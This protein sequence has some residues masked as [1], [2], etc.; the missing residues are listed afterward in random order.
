MSGILYVVGTPIGNL[1]DISE[2]ALDTLSTCDF[3]AAEDTRVTL[4]LLNRFEIK[5]TLI[6]YH[7]HNKTEAGP[8]ILDRLLGG[9]NCALV[10]DAGMPA[11]SDPGEDLVKLC[12]ENSVEVQAIPGP[13]ALI[14]AL[15]V[16]GMPS[17]RFV[18]EGFLPA[19]KKER[20]QVLESIS[21]EERTLILY[22]APHRLTKTLS[23]L[24]SSLGNRETAVVRELTKIHEEVIITD[25]EK[26][27]EKYSAAEPKGE[28]VLI[29]RG[30]ERE[31][32][33]MT[34]EQAVKY[35]LELVKGGESKSDAAKKAAKES[36]FKKNDIYSEIIR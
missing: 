25:L 16:S 35:A 28:F 4:K 13:S 29:I 2:R 19:D 10:T 33:S 22:E 32:V 8:K 15:A 7:E 3:I 24:L 21:G 26:A 12:R 6:S 20:A 14:T 31:N 36:G 1:G 30:K 5:N 17:R 27:L 18:F 23:D 9:E 11:I 34:F